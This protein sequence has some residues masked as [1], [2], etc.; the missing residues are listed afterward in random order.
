MNCRPIRVDAPWGRWY[1]ANTSHVPSLHRALHC[2]P[3]GKEPGMTQAVRVIYWNIGE[4]AGSLSLYLTAILAMAIMTRGVLRDIQRWRRGRP[5]RRIA[6]LPARL[7]ESLTQ[8]FG[9]QRV[10]R[11]RRPGMMHALIFFGFLALFIGTDIIA[12]EEDFTLPLIGPD[13]GKILVGTF[14]QSYELILDTM[15][16]VF[17]AGLGWATWRRYRSRPARLDNRRTD[18]WVL[19][20]LLY[21]ALTGYMLEGLRLANQTI[22]TAVVYDQ[23]WARSSYV[24]YACASLFR[25]I[26]LGGGAPAALGI[27]AVLWLSHMVITF[28]FIA[29]IPFSKFKHLF[30]TPINTFFRDLEPKGALTPIPDMEAQ[31]ER[32]TPELGVAS[33][34]DFTWKQRLDFDACMRCGRCQ[35]RCPATASGS[36]LSPKYLITKLADLMREQPILLRNG[37][38]AH[39]QPDGDS[40]PAAAEGGLVLRGNAETIP[41]VESKLFTDN[42][43]WSCTTCRAC[44][45]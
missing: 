2:Q 20:T 36:D 3:V 9:Q 13:A 31:I 7:R 15:G 22:G 35:A 26:G 39:V 12:V 14:Y 18:L 32:D 8:V 33:L 42:E 45:E 4:V 1:D 37:Q 24:G 40:S 5:D 10:L 27:H 29:S 17:L 23:P 28:A 19:L 43:L 38:T 21:L 30:Y 44:V 11:D 25:A 34:A 16:L 6:D 41:L